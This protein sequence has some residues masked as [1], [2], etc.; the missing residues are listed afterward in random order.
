[1][2]YVVCQSCQQGLRISPGKH[3]EAEALFGHGEC[4]SCWECG[5]DTETL[6]AADPAALALSD[7][8]D[9]SPEEAYAALNGLGL[10]RERECSAQAVT[11]LLT[12]QRVVA[13]SARQI[14]N[15]HRCI[16]QQLELEDGTRIYLGSSAYGATVY[17]VA[18]KHSYVEASIA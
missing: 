9:V 11:E 8:V 12:S 6:T 14:R 13:V 5:K 17:R 2:I 15:S 3:G 4:F 7:I 10:P 16:V 18:P 1:M